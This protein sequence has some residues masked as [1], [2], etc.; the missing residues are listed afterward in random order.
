MQDATTTPDTFTATIDRC[1][2]AYQRV[3]AELKKGATYFPDQENQHKAY[4]A[5]SAELPILYDP[6]SFR[7]YVA[8]IAKG[9]A[10]GAVDI[11]DAGRLCHIVQTAMSIWK[12]VNLTLPALQEKER[13]AEAKAQRQAT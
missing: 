4:L 11:A 7:L 1:A 3:R 12:L 13:Q 10:I 8:C 9:V 5:F 2:A 6:D